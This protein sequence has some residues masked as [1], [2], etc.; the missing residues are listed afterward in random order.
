[1]QRFLL[2]KLSLEMTISIYEGSRLLIAQYETDPQKPDSKPNIVHSV[3]EKNGA[4]YIPGSTVKG[5]VRSRAEYVSNFLNQGLGA[6]HIFKTDIDHL[7]LDHELSC[8]SRFDIR[9][10][11]G[12]E[13]SSKEIFSQACPV[14]QIF[15][16]NYLHSRIDFSDFREFNHSAT[17]TH[18]THIA[19]DRSTGG[20]SMKP[21]KHGKMRGKLFDS[22]Y[23]VQ[24]TFEGKILIENFQI[25]QLGLLGLLL[26]DLD[27]GLIRFGHKQSSGNGRMQI[28]ELSGYVKILAENDGDNSLKGIMALSERTQ[29]DYRPD[30]DKSTDLV[31]LGGTVWETRGIWREMQFSYDKAVDDISINELPVFAESRRQALDYMKAF[32]YPQPMTTKALEDLIS[33]ESEVKE[34]G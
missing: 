28:D 21:D 20:V 15:G 34:V 22:P 17:S 25:W 24:G 8:G 14:C 3:K 18:Q 1:M 7:P 6:C 29:S 13:P 26:Q 5:C 31:M 4:Y 23:L 27:D 2:N 32:S 16:H 33:L 19:V 30:Y 10:K 12:K 11:L 9:K